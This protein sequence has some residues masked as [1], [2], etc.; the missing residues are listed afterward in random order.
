M[1]TSFVASIRTLHELKRK[2][3]SMY[4]YGVGP[5]DAHTAGPSMDVAADASR[6][7]A[8]VMPMFGVLLAAI[9]IAL[10]VRA[11]Q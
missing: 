8:W 1:E 4:A 9:L 3:R 10:T 5:Y 6:V 7:P 2:A 11:L